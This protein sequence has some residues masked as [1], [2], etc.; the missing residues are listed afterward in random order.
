VVKHEACVHHTNDP[1]SYCIGQWNIRIVTLAL[2]LSISSQPP[3][4][5]F[6][7]TDVD[8]LYT[9]NPR[10]DPDAKPIREVPDLDMLRV[11][12]ATKGTQWGTGG[13]A[14]K[15]V[16]A[17]MATAVGCRMAICNFSEP[18]NVM[19]IL[20]GEPV[21]TVFHPRATPARGR[22]RWLLS[23]PV[24]GRIELD[25]GALRAVRDRRKSLFSAGVVA[26]AGDFDAQDAISLCGPDGIEF[27]RGLA[28]YARDEVQIVK[29]MSSK[30]FAGA[31][32]YQGQEEIVHRANICLLSGGA[33]GEDSDQDGGGEESD[34]PT[35][36][37]PSRAATPSPVPTGLGAAA[38]VDGVA[39][40]LAE[41]QQRDAATV[42]VDGVEARLVELQQR[43]EERV[44]AGEAVPF[45]SYSR[46]AEGFL[47][48]GR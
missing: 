20:H 44:A 13:M 15:L 16:A 43:E 42:A 26:A 47:L 29:G 23:V 1:T 19:R 40:R 4:R 9:A 12:T 21:G 24:R 3:C 32:G 11:D 17:R 46:E 18:A 25:P 7:L 45:G 48:G 38:A 36:E 6:L 28:N 39:M 27:A 30:E 34:G 8:S 22:K 35:P 14:T 41:L 37:G 2:A 31:L 5:L 10:T 33:G